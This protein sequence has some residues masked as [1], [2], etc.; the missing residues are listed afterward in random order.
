VIGREDVDVEV[1]WSDDDPSDR[2]AVRLTHKETGLQAESR[3]HNS[4]VANYDAALSEL[5][6]RLAELDPQRFANPL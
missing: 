3:E 4:Q 6:R 2:S 1:W 5:E